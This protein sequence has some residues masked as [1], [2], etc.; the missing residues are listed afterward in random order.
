MIARE[1]L[2]SVEL[3]SPEEDDPLVLDHPLLTFCSSAIVFP[4][5]IGVCSVGLAPYLPGATT[6]VM[7]PIDINPINSSINLSLQVQLSD[8][9]PSSYPIALGLRFNDRPPKEFSLMLMISLFSNLTQSTPSRR[10]EAKLESSVPSSPLPLFKSHTVDY[11]LVKAALQF[12]WPV[13]N[14]ILEFVWE[15]GLSIGRSYVLVVRLAVLLSFIP[16]LYVI[17]CKFKAGGYSRLNIFVV[18]TPALVLLAFLCNFLAAICE[19]FRSYTLSSL[20]DDLLRSYIA[21]YSVYLLIPFVH[22]ESRGN[23]VFTGPYF[24]C[25]FCGTFLLL[26]DV[27]AILADS[28]EFFPESLIQYSFSWW[29][30]G[31]FIVYLL[32]YGLYADVAFSTLLESKSNRFWYY[33][34]VHGIA[35]FGSLFL[36]LFSGRT[37]YGAL[38]DVLPIVGT[39]IYVQLMFHG[40]QET[41]KGDIYPGERIPASEDPSMNE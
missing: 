6:R 29:I 1:Q 8:L 40:H 31:L 39:A 35:D 21:F 23:I 41:K 36:L 7:E 13:D 16:S 3:Q 2:V 4:L 17:F 34:L 33:A 11:S 37:G 28:V 10:F 9:A 18:L 22:P 15:Y 12:S 30:F 27:R 38:T 5:L 20:F 32:V 19:L 25:V 14:A 26:K 24:V